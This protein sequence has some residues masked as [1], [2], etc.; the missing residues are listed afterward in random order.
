MTIVKLHTW[1][2]SQY[3]IG[4]VHGSL[5]NDEAKYGSSAYICDISQTPNGEGYTGC[6]DYEEV[7]ESEAKGETNED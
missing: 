6:D 5:V 3:C 2:I 7:G 1:P 4:C